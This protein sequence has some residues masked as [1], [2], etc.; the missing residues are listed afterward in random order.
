[1]KSAIHKI[2]LDILKSQ[3]QYSL[4]MKKRE[5]AREI[6]I[7]LREGG[8]PYEIGEECFAIFSG[9]KSDGTPFE[10]NCEIKDNTVVYKITEQTTS[11]IGLV[12]CEIKLYGADNGLICSPRFTIAVVDKV[13]SEEDSLEKDDEIN[14]LTELYSILA[15]TENT[16]V[17]AE[18]ERKSAEKAR[19]SA[20]EKRAIDT[21][22]AIKSANSAAQEAKDVADTLRTTLKNGDF[23]G[24]KGDKGEKG[25]KGD[26]G[27]QGEQGVQGVK[28]DK[29]AD[30]VSVTHSWNGTVLTVTSASG[31]SSSDLKGVKGDSTVVDKEL[32]ED[33]VNPVEGGATKKYIDGEV[34]EISDTFD[35][36]VN[37]YNEQTNLNYKEVSTTTGELGD[38]KY[39]AVTQPIFLKKGEY[40]ITHDTANSKNFGYVS[41]YDTDMVFVEKLNLSNTFQVDSEKKVVHL[42]I[43]Q[44]C[45][46]RFSGIIERITSTELMLVRGTELPTEYV[47]Y[48]NKIKAKHLPIDTEMSDESTNP[49]QNKVAK[50]YTDN[51]T[52]VNKYYSVD[53]TTFKNQ[54]VLAYNTSVNSLNMSF[55]LSIV[56]MVCE[57]EVAQPLTDMP[58]K[59]Q[60][61]F[62]NSIVLNK[63]NFKSIGITSPNLEELY[64]VSYL[65]FETL[66]QLLCTT[67]GNSYDV[68][69][70][71]DER[72]EFIV[73][74]VG[75]SVEFQYSDVAE[76]M[77]NTVDTI[78]NSP[79]TKLVF[80]FQ[81]QE[82]I[83]TQEATYQ[84]SIEPI[85]ND[86]V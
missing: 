61:G 19:Q 59:F 63:D 11:V 46:V 18:S 66:A 20:E 15:T 55:A 13:V 51:N 40:T 53:I 49:V 31:T 12:E 25:D 69:I 7:T 22:D 27:S 4:Q 10:H 21:A 1:M 5:T 35:K 60:V 52:V 8:S 41:F 50:A 64:D 42:V 65:S 72:K 58:F 80:L 75:L 54:G 39:W 62:T 83:E 57:N 79:D 3:S 43:E 33:G 67:Q 9:R 76:N 77:K 6:H 37:L 78:L 38:N 34:R 24:D 29:G 14:A 2:S 44:N 74:N 70:E 48:K 32:T 23:K 28:G 16:R 84:F 30:G 85:I 86:E 26:T 36:S 47:P 81:N 56:L 71:Y 45:Y 73:L 82:K 68:K 17:K